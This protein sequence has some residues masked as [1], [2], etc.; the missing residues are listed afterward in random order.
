M[1][2]F[3]R[4]LIASSACLLAFPV[5]A[6]AQ[7][8]TILV[9]AA[10]LPLAAQDATVS[11]SVLG[12]AEL[13]ARGP[14]FAA[15]IL[16][17][18]PGLA[19]SRSGPAGSL[20][21]IRARGAEANHVLVL[22]DGVEAASPFTGEA[23][24]SNFLFD[25]LARIE[26]ARG[27]QSALWGAD[28]IGGVIAMQTAR[29][30]DGTL[31]SLRME[32]GSFET[33]R[34][35]G[36]LARGDE[37]RGFGV[38]LGDFRS[39]GIDIS[40]QDGER[41]GYDNTQLAFNAHSALGG[42]WRVEGS[43]RWIDYT[44]ASD[45]DTDFNGV[46][47]DTDRERRGEQFFSALTVSGETGLSGLTLSHELAARLTD[48][49]NRSF[50]DGARTGRNL[51]QRRQVRYQVSSRWQ[52][53]AVSHRLTGLVENE[54]DKTKN[55]AGPGNGANQTRTIETRALAFDYG[56]A[57][58]PLDLTVSARRES[59][60]RFDDSTTWR[61]GAAWSFEPVG[62]RLRASMGEGV[63]NPGVFELFGF[64]PDFF[65][66]NPDLVPERSKG[67][68][69]GW[70]QRLL[71]DRGSA[72]LTYF[73]SELEDEIFT[74]FSVFPLTA[75]NAAGRS[76]RE[77]I[78]LSGRFTV[79]PAVYL[80]GSASWLQSEEGGTAEIRRP[81]QLASLTVSWQPEGPLS[82]SISADYTGEQTDTDFGSFQTV[83]L[84]AYTLVSGQLNWQPRDGVEFYA[85]GENLLDEDYRDVFGFH[86]PGRAVYFGLR[87]HRG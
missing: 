83:T 46:L 40:G 59:N 8:E 4:K 44:S 25:D 62:G 53:G 65:V 42:S 55:D 17:A 45:A 60:D 5:L 49:R 72:E 19:V 81:E 51:G 38:S 6:H 61:A 82:A 48:D 34:I 36:R 7:D 18:V 35:A 56:L 15:D 41:D 63:K 39:E 24:F 75:G 33:R 77:G 47:D 69:I 27:E 78:E 85:R 16:R 29:P 74:D 20:T 64:F 30:Q 31:A 70:E 68:E 71:D 13:E 58:G 22:I 1:S 26:V 52:S 73:S 50:A 2:E 10:R 87:L 86:T 54:R 79:T 28:A 80:F 21:Q 12:E 66:G 14:L 23:D 84:D 11:V 3:K 57:R 43:G 32:A 67:W 9:T 37:A 76:T